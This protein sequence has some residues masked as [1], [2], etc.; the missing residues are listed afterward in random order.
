MLDCAK[1]DWAQFA[2]TEGWSNV[3]S[4]TGMESLLLSI[5]FPLLLE[6]DSFHSK[7]GADQTSMLDCDN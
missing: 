4:G 6:G 1:W 3:N 2:A 7:L 5:V